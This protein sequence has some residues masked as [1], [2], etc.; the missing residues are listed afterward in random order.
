MHHSINHTVPPA[1]YRCSD[2]G[3]GGHGTY[4]APGGCTLIALFAVTRTAQ[5]T[6]AEMKNTREE[7]TWQFLT[8]MGSIKETNLCKVYPRKTGPYLSPLFVHMVSGA[9]ALAKLISLPHG[10]MILSS[11][12]VS[13]LESTAK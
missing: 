13:G 12:K 10:R 1:N 4:Y 9:P 8:D 3:K 2:E 7:R 6:E 5:R 11:N